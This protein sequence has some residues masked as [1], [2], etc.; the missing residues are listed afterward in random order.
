[1][2]RDQLEVLLRDLIQEEGEVHHAYKDSERF[3]TIGIGTLID[4]RAGGG[5]THEEAVYL[6]TNRIKIAEAAVLRALPWTARLSADVFRVLVDMAFNLGVGGFLA[7]H[8]FL[9]ALKAGDRKA[10]RAAMLDSKWAK[11]VGSRAL[12]LADV[13]HPPEGDGA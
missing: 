3:W 2:D 6:C 12:R 1:V 11:Q 13:I 9:G 7:F 5:I 8:D 4:E 10:A